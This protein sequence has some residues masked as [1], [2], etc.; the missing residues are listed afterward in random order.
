MSETILNTKLTIN[1]RKYPWAF[2]AEKALRAGG[3]YHERNVDLILAET[4]KTRQ[5]ITH[6]DLIPLLREKVRKDYL[7][8]GKWPL[9]DEGKPVG[10]NQELAKY[11]S[12]QAWLQLRAHLMRYYPAP[13]ADSQAKKKDAFEILESAHM[14]FI[15]KATPA[16]WKKAVE[17]GYVSGTLAQARKT[18]KTRSN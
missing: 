10:K 5:G 18:V 8:M 1:S 6:K 12:G 14:T 11:V 2:N 17:K 3:E 16:Q 13:D 7:D 15:K 4:G 9:N